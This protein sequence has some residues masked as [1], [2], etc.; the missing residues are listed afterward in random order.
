MEFD[1]QVEAEVGEQEAATK[2]TQTFTA[3]QVVAVSWAQFTRRE[4]T[5]LAFSFG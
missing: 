3:T 5:Q 1:R 4:Q 2:E